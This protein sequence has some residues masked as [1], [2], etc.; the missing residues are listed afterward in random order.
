MFSGEQTGQKLIPKAVKVI[1][2][3]SA[4]WTWVFTI[5]L[6]VLSDTTAASLTY[7]S[8]TG[9][10]QAEVCSSRRNYLARE[11]RHAKMPS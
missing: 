4:A 11:D 10:L 6:S 2:A 5:M 3:C 9:L 8:I 7:D 1:T